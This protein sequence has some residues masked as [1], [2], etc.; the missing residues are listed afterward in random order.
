MTTSNYGLY[1]TKLAV[2]GNGKTPAEVSFSKGLNVISGASETGKSYIIECIDYI[3][4]GKDPP[5]N[6]KEAEGYQKIQAELRT[7]DGRIFTLSR[8]FND[9]LILMSECPYEEFGQSESLKLST[10]HSD[11]KDNLSAYLLSL[12]QLYGKQLKKNQWNEKKSISFRDLTKFCIIKETKIINDKSPIFDGYVTDETTNKSLFKLLLTGKDDTSLEQLE[13]PEYGKARIKGKIELVKADIESKNKQITELKKT[14]ET[15]TTDEINVQIQ[16][17]VAI[18]EGA[19]KDIEE[20]E[21]KRQNIWVELDHLKSVMVQ[22]QAIK[23]RFDILNNVYSSDLKRLD[24]INEGA[25]GIDQLKEINCPLCDSLIDKKL[26]EP[27]SEKDDNF[28]SSVK[29]EFDKIQLK[30][31]EL[32]EAIKEKE[33]IMESAGQSIAKK[34]VEFDAI[35]KYI[36][37]KLKPIHELHS[38]ELHNFMKLNEDKAQVKLLESQIDVL[39]TSLAHLLRLLNEKQQ[40]AP[41]MD[42]GVDIYTELSKEIKDF[43][44]SWGFDY[45]VYFDPSAYDITIDNEKRSNSGKGYRALYLSAFMLGVLQFCVKKDLKHP[46]FLVL[47]SP[48]V[49]YKEQDKAPE[50]VKNR[51]YESLAQLSYINKVQIIIIENID[52]PASILNNINYIHFTK[53]VN[54]P[55]YGFYPIS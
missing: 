33:A 35:D 26:L 41:E 46:R 37:D 8:Q 7:F 11:S 45:S 15:L 34:Q 21:K 25:F 2:L 31:K 5:K 6:I 1:L 22:N 44:F 43:I 4:A 42:A 30:Q 36:G 18:V 14:S 12:L 20:Q 55:R 3:L 39:N 19:H 24:F 53:N 9:N 50:F 52:P 32:R 29:S 38:E 28:L 48:L 10:Q 51:F 40:K 27:Y 13:N 23:K 17:L 54:V 47:D 16:K 49:T